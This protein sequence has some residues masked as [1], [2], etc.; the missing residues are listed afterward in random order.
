MISATS[1]YVF[2]S[3]AWIEYFR[4]SEKGEKVKALFDGIR[5]HTPSVVLAEVAYWYSKQNMKFEERI[6][7]IAANS[8]ITQTKEHVAINAG[9]IKNF[10][11]KKY[12]NNFGTIDAIIL[13]TARDLKAT[14]VT[15][16]YHFKP[17]EDVNYI[18]E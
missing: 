7:F 4:G 12:K 13:A 8:A 15:G 16:D 14:V 9:K 3:H 6:S 2:D 1:N 10:V 17:F 18:G 5:I 11:R